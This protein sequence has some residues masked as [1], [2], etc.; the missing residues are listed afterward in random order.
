MEIREAKQLDL[1]SLSLLFHAYRHLSVSLP[2]ASTIQ[3]SKDWLIERFN[4]KEAIFL[5]AID[6][7]NLLGFATLYQGFSSI[8]LRKYWALNDLYVRDKARGK[9]IGSKLLDAVD[10]YAITTNAKGVE[11][12]VSIGNKSAQHLYEQFGYE[13]N[14]QYKR[15]FKTN[16]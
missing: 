2:I 5:I 1:E 6:D 3:D 8:S 16:K 9:G 12:E 15:Y 11:L 4:S 7:G 13:E 14:T 10:R